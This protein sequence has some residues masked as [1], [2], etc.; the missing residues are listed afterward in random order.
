MAT[1]L[2]PTYHQFIHHL[3]SKRTS[4]SKVVL[5]TG[6]DYFLQKQDLR[7]LLS[8][9]KEVV[10][11]PRYVDEMYLIQEAIAPLFEE[12]DDVHLV[13]NPEYDERYRIIYEFAVSHNKTIKITTVYDF[14][15][16]YLKKVYIP[17]SYNENNPKLS[18][19]QTNNRF[20]NICKNVIDLSVSSVLLAISSPLWLLSRIKIA[21]ESPGPIFYRQSRVGLNQRE[22]DCIK[23]RSMRL[24][25][26]AAGAQFSSK[27]DKRVFRYGAFMRATRIDELPQLL[28]VFRGEISLVGPRPERRVFTESFEEVIPH[29]STRHLIKPGITGYAQ[30]M[31]PYGA[32]AKDA[33]H[34]LMY[35]LYYIKNWTVGLEMQIIW[36]TVVTVLDYRGY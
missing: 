23:F 15:E 26:E 17:E 9:Y 14:C 13:A 16:K 27:K 3:K 5:F 20:Q 33:R 8:Q 4:K 35:D 2:Y 28:S 36:K 19:I 18:N 29:Y 30:V 11:I 25:A 24:D 6:Y 32:G 12:Y 31:Y 34:K 22:F 10:L 1:R 7:W 21:Q